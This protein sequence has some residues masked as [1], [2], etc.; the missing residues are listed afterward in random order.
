MKPKLSINNKL[1]NIFKYQKYF[2]KIISYIFF[3][4]IHFFIIYIFTILYINNY[5]G[6]YYYF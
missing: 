3:L 4:N 2:I 6:Y 1:I 5:K